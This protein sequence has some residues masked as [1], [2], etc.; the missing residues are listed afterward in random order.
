MGA[1]TMSFVERHGLWTDEQFEAAARAEALIAEKK[2]E[3]VRLSFADQ[4]G[5]LRGK[6]VMAGDAARAMRHGCTITTTLLAKDTSHRSVFPVFTAGGGFGIPEMQGGGD[7]LMVADPT[8]FRV[9]PWAPQTGWVLCDIYFANGKPVP[10]STRH[11]Y[12]RALQK[13]ADAGFDY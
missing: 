5:I 10:F 1:V 9:L 12:R 11:L 8:T 6:T 2:L 3:V 7:F 4:H 13:L